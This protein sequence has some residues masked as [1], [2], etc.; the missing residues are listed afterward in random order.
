MKITCPKL[1]GDK[2][3][4]AILFFLTYCNND[5]LGKTKLN[6]LFY[7]L[8]FISYR[9]KNKT[10]TGDVYLH[11]TYGPVPENLDEILVELKDE[12]SIQVETIP[13]KEAD[14]FKFIALSD[15]KTKIFSKYEEDLLKYICGKFLLWSTEK[16]V[17]QTHLEA[18][19]FYSKPYEKVEMKYS[20]NI[21]FFSYDEQRM[22]GKQNEPFL[23][24][25]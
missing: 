24:E 11:K 9:D 20:S 22:A 3:K 13:Y 23:G 18:P 5:Y 12:G 4:N 16:I 1:N 2:Y 19:W 14:K 10:I 7:Y 25:M 17:G 6:K 21:D 8:D 15:P